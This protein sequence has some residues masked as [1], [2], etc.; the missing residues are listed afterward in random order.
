MLIAA[1]LLVPISVAAAEPSQALEAA[2]VA[3]SDFRP[4]DA[5]RF[6]DA[7]EGPHSHAQHVRLYEQRGIALAYL[8]RSEEA[9]QAFIRMLALQPDRVLSY[10]LSPKVTF[11]FERARRAVRAS[12]EPGVDLSWPRNLRT[13]DSVPVDIEV[14]ADPFRF[15]R[16]LTLHYRLEGSPQWM[17]ETVTLPGP[18]QFLT[19][20]LP[21]LGAGTSMSQAMELYA[22]AFDEGGNEVLL[23]G[24][25]DRP[26]EVD[27][28]FEPP[29]PWFDQWWVWATAGALVVAGVGAGFII[30]SESQSPTVDGRIRVPL[31]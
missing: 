12:E 6:L 22:V 2:G 5:L 17:A 8:D 7:A 14:V 26:R 1:L 16:T 31:P 29:A 30:S 28:R 23:F 3:L 21:P 15:L 10:T 20:D 13:V 11:L 4:E 18:G 27:L 24:R 9:V 19:V 25:S